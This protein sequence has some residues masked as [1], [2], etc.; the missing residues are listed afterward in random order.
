MKL[1]A[2]LNTPLKDLYWH[3][4]YERMEM[5]HG[6]PTEDEV[7][8]G[9]KFTNCYRAADR[10][11]QF[12]I[13]NIL[14]PGGVAD[15]EHNDPNQLLCDVLLFKLFN[16][17]ETWQHWDNQG[18]SRDWTEFEWE[19]FADAADVMEPPRFNAAYITPMWITPPGFD[20]F[21]PVKTTRALQTIQW[22]LEHGVAES[23][24][25]LTASQA[26]DQL[27]QVPNFGPFLTYQLV[28]DLGYSEMYGWGENS[29]TKAGPQ[30][31]EGVAQL[32]N[33]KGHPEKTI[34]WM[35]EHQREEFARLGLP[36]RNLFGRDLTLIDCQNL[37][38][39]FTK[40]IKIS[41]RVTKNLVYN[42]GSTKK[43]YRVYR[44]TG[45]PHQLWFPNK[46]GVNLDIPEER[47]LW[48]PQ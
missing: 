15:P 39:E 19:Y 14:Y 48:V 20:E 3:F 22:C 36:F 46:W 8:K 13:G 47:R 23:L 33:Q 9:I 10:V 21:E 26:F 11:S 28:T 30:A 1:L 41:G 31:R 45:I 37:F 2:P 40:Y 44:R 7:L 34:Q 4:A 29:F 6:T 27:S 16:R 24:I 32:T 38:C 17:I 43:R 18:L 12:L 5:F 35:K 42:V 25:G